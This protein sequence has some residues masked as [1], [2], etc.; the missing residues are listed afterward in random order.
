MRLRTSFVKCF[1]G[2]LQAF[3][4]GLQVRAEENSGW[5]VPTQWGKLKIE[6]SNYDEISYLPVELG[7][8]MNECVSLVLY[9]MNECVKYYTLP[10][11]SI[12][13]RMKK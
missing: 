5:N 11:S 13:P 3:L 6:A 12:M 9:T 8:W 4:C 10:H 7:W 2:D 1:W